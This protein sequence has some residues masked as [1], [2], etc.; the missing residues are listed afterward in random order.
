MRKTVISIRF[1]PAWAGLSNNLYGFNKKEDIGD[2]EEMEDF[3]FKL[4][5]K[6]FSQ[7][8]YNCFNYFIVY[9]WFKRFFPNRII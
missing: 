8:S 6:I 4:A 9:I 1:K 2:L 3:I 7:Y 5:I